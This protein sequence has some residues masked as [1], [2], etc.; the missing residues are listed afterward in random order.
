MSQTANAAICAP[1]FPQNPV[2]KRHIALLFLVLLS[3]ITFLDRLCIAVAGPRMQQELGISPAQWGWV[4]GAFVLAYGIFEIPSGGLGDRLGQRK[5]LTRIAVWW[6]AFTFLTGMASGFATLIVTQFLFGAGEAGAYPNISGSIKRWFPAEE[7]ARA[8]GFVWS[9]SRLGGALSPLLVAPILTLWGWR[10][11][12]W[13]FGVAGFLWASVWYF[14][15]RDADIE[16][17]A[18]DKNALEDVDKPI[19]AS[20]LIHIP[21]RSLYRS[22]TVRFIVAM[23]FCYAWGSWFFLSWFPTYL[24]RGR[25][26]TL[27]EMGIFSSFPFLL[28]AAGNLLGG[29]LSDFL[30][31][32]HGLKHGRRMIGAAALAASGLLVLITAMS[33]GK[34]AGVALLAAA[35]GMMDLMLPSAWAVCL[36]VGRE[37]AGAVTGVM[38]TAG[39]C[40]G[41]VCTLVFGYTVKMTGNYN[42][43][44][45]AIG[46]MLL[47]STALFW[48]IDP[49]QQ[50]AESEVVS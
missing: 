25:G 48:Q 15:Y 36:D 16:L 20:Q 35:F 50:L 3:V 27:K 17:S 31:E 34:A 23:Y 26:L 8:Q 7:R 9:A 13:I 18:K 41:F 19:A 28:G 12:F 29:Y 6:S 2:E 30:V 4:L 39:L 1:D 45:L 47:V 14:W 42:L 5:V 24:V 37:H 46:V 49:T 21:W 22:R 40:G 38:N 33:H 11:S 32:R 44:L 43:P 10:T